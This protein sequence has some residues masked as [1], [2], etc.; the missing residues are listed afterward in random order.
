[1]KRRGRNC[2]G[3]VD[4]ASSC[5]ESKDSAIVFGLH[6]DDIAVRSS[7]IKEFTQKTR[8]IPASSLLVSRSFKIF[9]IGLIMSF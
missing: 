8:V 3:A 5:P 6:W 2:I 1:M 4:I 7:P 9:K